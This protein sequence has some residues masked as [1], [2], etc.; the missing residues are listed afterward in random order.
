[1]QRSTH[2][3]STRELVFYGTCVCSCGWAVGW[4]TWYDTCVAPLSRRGRE[5][6]SSRILCTKARLK[7]RPSSKSTAP[8]HFHYFAFIP[9]T[10]T[11]CEG[12]YSSD[13]EKPYSHVHMDLNIQYPVF[14]LRRIPLLRLYEKSSN[15]GEPPRHQAD[16]GSVHQ[17]LPARTRPLIVF[18]H[19]PV[20]VEPCDRPLHHPPPLGK[21]TKPLG[22]ISFCQSA[23]TPSLAHSLAHAISTSSGAGFFGRSTRSTLQPNVFS[24]QSLPLSSPR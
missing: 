4:R 10:T 7:V 20:L 9:S 13:W 5:R 22:G 17:R 24:T 18:A 2:R 12:F 21:T 8:W 16:H 1:M 19:P 15:T 6:R 23:F 11:F 3:R 14:G